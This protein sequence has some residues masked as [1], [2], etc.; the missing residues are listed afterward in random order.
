MMPFITPEQQAFLS[1]N[2]HANMQKAEWGLLHRNAKIYQSSLAELSQWIT[3]YV[4]EDS[5]AK[6]QLLT[7][8][9]QLQQ[10]NIEPT[11]PNL[12][13]SLAALQTYLSSNIN[14]V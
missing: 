6:K 7:S 4:A 9:Q 10:I 11:L 8:L 3:K 1:Q 5:T 12:N 13:R 14:K 2:L